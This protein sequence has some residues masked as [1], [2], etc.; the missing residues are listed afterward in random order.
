MTSALAH[1]DDNLPVGARTLGLRSKPALRLAIGYQEERQRKGGGT[2]T[3]P[4]KADHFIAKPG[5]DGQYAAAARKFHEVYS[6]EPKAIDILLP[7]ELSQ[8]L[9]IQYKAFAGGGS[10][11]GGGVL[12]AIGRTNFALED[13][14]G[15]P[16]V[17][18][19]WKQ[20][21][22][23]VEVE[24]TGLD[25][26]TAVGLGL[27]LYTTLRVGIPNVLGFGS[28]CEVQ[29]KGKETTDTLWAKLH[30]IYS[31]FGSRVTFAV[32]PKLVV[33]KSKARPVVVKDGESKRMT[34]T[35]YVLDIVVP[36]TVDEM[37][38]RIRD[39]A[40]LLPGGAA[41][42]LYGGAPVEAQPALAAP[43]APFFPTDA[44]LERALAASVLPLARSGDPDD[45]DPG[46]DEDAVVHEGEVV[47]D[48]DTPRDGGADDGGA[49]PEQ[50]GPS[51]HAVDRQDDSG[52]TDG[53]GSSPEPARSP[54]RAPASAGVDDEVVAEAEAAATLLYPAGRSKGKTLAEVNET[55]PKSIG[56][57][58][59][60]WKTEPLRTQV[61]AF[62][63]I[64][65]PE[66]YQAA[67]AAEEASA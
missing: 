55:D 46:P 32:K 35:I 23:V 11:E 17:I 39:R 65:A 67:L 61:R 12:T 3:V 21:G 62:A 15:G 49:H 13:Y 45:G 56:W 29:S 60:N 7:A 31:L 44:D 64:Y 30:D 16:D 38:D 63:R 58:L 5:A 66:L 41:V 10:G 42:A 19:I 36:E 48:A 14:V 25:D 1:P 28:F 33:R 54:Y 53:A 57:L 4:V 6:A 26:P 40:A 47:G 34:T 37:F 59:G 50:Q 51:S 27:A 8:A 22:E 9:T 43:A 20:T 18:T 2:Y 24:I 52:A